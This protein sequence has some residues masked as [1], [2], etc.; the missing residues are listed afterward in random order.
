M[1]KRWHRRQSSK[2]RKGDAN[3]GR[4]Q[5]LCPKIFTRRETQNIPAAN[6]ID[7]A[8]LDNL[9]Q[10]PAGCHGLPA[11]ALTFTGGKRVVDLAE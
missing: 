1:R 3:S 9:E 8:S 4:S 10:G 5:H 11:R 7:F 2:T 6:A